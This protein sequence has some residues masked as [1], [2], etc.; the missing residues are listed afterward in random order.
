MNPPQ[1]LGNVTVVYVFQAIFVQQ[2][3][4]TV[5]FYSNNSQ[6]EI[7]HEIIRIASD[8]FKPFKHMNIDELLTKRIS[9]AEPILNIVVLGDI[10]D[11]Y[12]RLHENCLYATTVIW[13]T[14]Q[15]DG[16][17]DTLTESFKVSSKVI[18]LTNSNLYTLNN[19]VDTTFNHI[20]LK[21]FS[22]SL[23]NQFLTDFFS[24]ESIKGSNLAIFTEFNAPNSE[25][26][27]IDDDYYI[28]G[29]DGIVAESLVERLNLKPTF[30]SS[31]GIKHP[32]YKNWLNGPILSRRLAYQH[33]HS[34]VLTKNV[35]KIFDHK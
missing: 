33:Y 17:N 12:K 15:N 9:Y 5:N 6:N 24:I 13:L 23:T 35:V 26:T 4:R 21:K 22:L 20:S 16:F 8:S 3:Y 7:F 28:I 31:V 29:P 18:V 25:L 10:S 19:F 11:V 30:S 32:N 2:N 27:Q 1:L 34:A 14:S